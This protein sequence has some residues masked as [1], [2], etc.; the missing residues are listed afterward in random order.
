[1]PLTTISG[2]QGK[3][4]LTLGGIANTEPHKAQTCF[5]SS[6]LNSGGIPFGRGVVLAATQTETGAYTRPLIELPITGGKFMGVSLFTDSVV[7]IL[8]GMPDDYTSPRGYL[9]DREL[10][11]V[12]EGLVGVEVVSAVTQNSPVFV[13]VTPGANHGKFR[14]DAASGA[15]IAVTG[16][17]FRGN[18]ASGE[19]V[20]LYLNLTV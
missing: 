10:S 9:A 17:A 8:N 11:V 15:A 5:S 14:A 19:T 1:M 2:M 3:A 18:A 13:V 7:G 16:A 12:Y 4:D 20:A 6:A